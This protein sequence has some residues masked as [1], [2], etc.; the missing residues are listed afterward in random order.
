MSATHAWTVRKQVRKY[1]AGSTRCRDVKAIHICA[2]LEDA[3]PPELYKRVCDN[4]GVWS[5]SPK[6]AKFRF[7]WEPVIHGDRWHRDM[8]KD[9]RPPQVYRIPVKFW[10]EETGP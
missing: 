3:T 10:V 1:Q 8:M 2:Q 9:W 6:H 5:E 7:A 4:D